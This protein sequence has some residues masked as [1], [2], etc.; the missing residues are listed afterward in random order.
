MYAH[1]TLSRLAVIAATAGVAMTPALGASTA[2]AKTPHGGPQP[3]RIMAK[4]GPAPQ[5]GWH[6]D[7]LARR[8]R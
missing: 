3:A 7:A 1:R 5:P 6:R 4:R 8:Y 2:S